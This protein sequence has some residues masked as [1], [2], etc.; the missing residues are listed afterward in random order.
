MSVWFREWRN[1]PSPDSPDC[2]TRSTSVKPDTAISHRSVRRGMWCFKSVPGLS[3]LAG[4]GA[5]AAGR[6]PTVSEMSL[7]ALP[8]TAGFDWGAMAGARPACSSDLWL[9]S[10]RTDFWVATGGG[11]SLL[12]V[13]G[14]ILLWHG[15]RELDAA[16]LLLSELHLGA[17][18]DAIVRR[19]L[20][21]RMPM[22][23]LAVPLAIV[24]ATYALVLSGWPLLVTTAILYLGAWHRGRQNLGIARHYQRSVG[25]PL[26]SRHQWLFAAAFY[27]PMIAGVAYY[28]STAPT[29]EGEAFHG[30]SLGP[31]LL[32]GLGCLA[33]T[34]VAA[35]L[36]WTIGRTG[37][38][39]GR[40]RVPAGGSPLVVHPAERW[41]VMANAVAFGSAYVVGAW[42][43]SF[44]L[45]LAVHHEVQYL[46]F[47][48]AVARRAEAPRTHGGVPE[49]RRLVRFAVWPAI[50]L[51]SWAAC[52]LSGLDAL[53]PFLTA[54][55]LGHYWLDG[56]IWTARARRLASA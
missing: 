15:D 16:D 36:Y 30:L 56:R 35:Y 31:Q 26:S 46:Y 5:R 47:T 17:T 20:W 24:I 10:E 4:D 25:G 49:L 28:T 50:G 14:L 42:A 32:W 51:A 18:Y 6:P 27:L 41:L 7:E 53:M 55:L 1:P 38:S 44:V 48:Y 2:A 39:G 29:H 21:R 43:A 52:T 3:R 12:V 13:L 8:E 33:V 40:M 22:D 9:V 19:R 37:T 54:G 11:A 34:S 23:V 45:V